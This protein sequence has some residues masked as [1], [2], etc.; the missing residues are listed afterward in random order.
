MEKE[1]FFGKTIDK[2]IS[3][4]FSII[5]SKEKR[6]ERYVL[7]LMIVGFI[8]RL[9]AALNQGDLADD[10]LYAS[11]SAGI[12]KSG[13]ISTHSNPPLFAYLTDFAYTLFGYTTLMSRLWPL[14]AGTLLILLV[15]LIVRKLFDKKIAFFAALFATFSNFL[16]KMT[17]TEASLVVFFLSFFGIYLGMIYLEKNKFVYLVLS[18]VLFGLATLVKYNAPF[19]IFAFLVF[20]C[21]YKKRRNETIFNK[22]NIRH[23]IIFFLIILVFA[24]PFLSFNYLLYKD[25]GIVDVYFSRIFKLEKTQQIYSGL[26]GQ[27]TTFFDNALNLGNYGNLWIVWLTDPLIFIFSVIGLMIWVRRK[28][29]EPLYFVLLL[30]LI[31]FILQ[32]GGSTLPK[33]FAFMHILMVI[34]AGY[35]LS[36]TYSKLNG[37]FLKFLLL[38]LVLGIMVFYLGASYGTPG[39]YMH[40]SA[41]SSLKS[42][43]SG[44]VGNNDL[45]IFDPRIYTAKSFWLATDNHFLLGQHFA[46]FY[47]Y[48][49]NL[50]GAKSN[51]KIHI[52]ECISDDCGWGPAAIKQINESAEA[53]ISS[54]KIG[55]RNVKQ[56][57]SYRTSWNEFLDS[58]EAL[59]YGVYT[60]ELPMDSRL[61]EQTDKLNA[62]Y[63][64]PYMYKNMENYLFDYNTSGMGSML[65][66]LSRL[67]IWAAIILMIFILIAIFFFL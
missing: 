25:K 39:S 64:V 27:G 43:I 38:V 5:Y 19:F 37:K 50:S 22:K 51:V 14:I 7:V 24:L 17:F 47:N 31:P 13:I 28:E 29:K 12:I 16:I 1:S 23:L 15:F 55:A 66:S 21:I 11:Q 45:I 40:K 26:A 18:A 44:N 42:Y 10:M 57:K 59:E 20:A 65:Q 67:I 61:V 35:L 33:H 4:F 48:D 3:W 36:M 34:P 8:L 62:F 53:L 52:I 2:V 41:T 6:V 46:E 56:I 58:K 32:T 63:F 49:K 30:L 54:L 9:V 60:L